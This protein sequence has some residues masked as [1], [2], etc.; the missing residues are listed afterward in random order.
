MK[1]THVAVH[2][3]TTVVVLLLLVVILGAYSYVV[4]PR[5]SSP[6]VVIPYIFVTVTYEGVS[7][8]DMESLVTVPIERKLTGMSGLKEIQS[9]SAEG[10]STIA[11]EFEADTDI[12]DALQ[13]V[14]DKVD[15]AKQDLPRDAEDPSVFEINISE[16]PIMVMSLTGNY[17]LAVL[18]ELAEDIEDRI[19]TIPGVLDV[20]IIGGVEREIQIEVDPD[21][22]AEYGVSFGDL[23]S[24]VSLENVN[25]PGGALDLGDGKY[26][27]RTPGEFKTPEEIENLVV[28]TGPGGAVFLRDLAVVRDGFKEITTI[29]RVNDKPSVTLTV[30]KRS[31]EN[32]IR[33]ADQV[34]TALKDI[35]RRFPPGVEVG[36][37][38]DESVWIRDMVS[39]LEN[40]ILSGMLL[41]LLVIFVSLGFTNALM[42]S[43]AI[44]V[45]MLITF[46]ALYFSDV[47]LNLVS[48]FSLILAVGMLV[49]NGIVVVENIHRHV[50]S[51][52]PPVEA[53]KIGADEVSWPITGS[54]L[55]TIAAFSPMFFWPGIWG[56]FMVYLPMTVSISLAAS[57]FVGIV[58]NPSL[59]ALLLR[60]HPAL[61]GVPKRARI[62]EVYERVLRLALRWRAVTITTAFTALIA[63][64]AV[65]LTTGRT[66]FLPEIEPPQ[67]QIDIKCPEGSNLAASDGVVRE[68][69]DIVR[70]YRDHVEFVIANVGRQAGRGSELGGGG[71]TTTHLS[72]VT[73]DFPRL[74][75]AEMTPSEVI[76][77]IRPELGSVTGAEIRIDKMGMGPPTGP[78]INIE[79]SGDDYQVLA[80]LARE[81]RAAIEHVPG[82]VDLRDDYNRGKPEVRVV[83][84]RVQAWK[85]GLNT[86][87]IG[88]IVKAAVNGRKAADFREGDKEY[89]VTVR[90]PRVFRED[91]SNLKN[92]KLVNATGQAVPFSAVAAVEQGAGLG[93]IRRINRKRTVT[94]SGEVE[95]KRRPP[96]VLADVKE[97]LSKELRM[98]PGFSIAYT[99][100]NKENEE[101]QAFLMKAFFV[102]LLLVAFVLVAQFNSVL[103]TLV[104]M[105]TVLLS[106]VGVFLGYLICRMP[107]GV[108]MSGIGCISLAGVVVNNGIVL[109][110]FINQLRAQGLSI[111]EAVI[112]AGVIRFRPVLLTAITT[113]IGLIPM[114]VGVSFNF[115]EFRWSIGGESTQWWGPMAIAVIF[116]LSFATVLTL[117]VVPVLYSA[118]A[119]LSARFA[120]GKELGRAE[121]RE[122][123]LAK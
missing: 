31:G 1:I 35:S 100:E 77:R 108:L 68:V 49:D 95:G 101:T 97:I 85:T 104:I 5:E 74:A 10:A 25:T 79:F 55:T 27:M 114:A 45:S 14:R 89:D 20:E 102:A 22:V 7:P 90:F 18:N 21:R 30:S 71:G 4:L 121:T 116:G 32:I 52:I 33:I 36:L 65:Y 72:R 43:L 47:T 48:L 119:G 103:Q 70:P 9:T 56:E 8:E 81:A 3:N 59:A 117:V 44:P 76:E 112:R 54:T 17:P 63:I 60:H 28:K 40:S 16:F 2:R 118:T 61:A 66:E 86:L 19:E 105:S 107:F 29:S 24:V 67:A 122:E 64:T 73:L 58:V 13:R 38:W 109:L 42:V 37:T 23:I 84:D 69:E 120:S 110:Q 78:P 75:E 26:L 34:K 6:E 39:D 12:E 93:T 92:M 123:V 57:L 11:I 94:V 87:L 50:Q 80:R 53:A 46:V 99:G 106:L 83:V 51:G 15:Q 113:V 96:E 111:E 41:V 91:L 62:L 82:L 115:R 88:E 98:P